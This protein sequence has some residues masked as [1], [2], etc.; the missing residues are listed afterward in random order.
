M[1]ER[2]MVGFVGDCLK[3]FIM[4]AKTRVKDRK[5]HRLSAK[6]SSAKIVSDK[7]SNIENVFFFLDH[8]LWICWL[9]VTQRTVR[10][11]RGCVWGE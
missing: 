7:I 11:G 6:I 5:Q 4:S 9:L 8:F 10:A 3:I 2:A 1:V